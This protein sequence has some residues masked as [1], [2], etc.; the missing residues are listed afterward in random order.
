MHVKILRPVGIPTSDTMS[1]TYRD[2][3]HANPFD[4]NRDSRYFY[5]SPAHEEALGRLKYLAEDGNFGLGMLSGT[6]GSGKSLIRTIFHA[7]LD[8]SRFSSV[9]IENSLLDLDG[10]LLEILSQM[11]GKRYHPEDVPDRYSKISEFKRLLHDDIVKHSRHLIISIDEAQML[12]NATLEGV[13][14]LTNINSSQQ[15]LMTV[16]LIGQPELQSVVKGLPQ[17]DQRIGL[18]CRIGNLDREETVAY[19]NHRIEIAQLQQKTSI[20][21]YMFHKL[22]RAT[23][24]N[25]RLINGL[26]KLALEHAR[27]NEKILDDSSLSAVISDQCMPWYETTDNKGLTS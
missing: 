22:Y 8:K 26:F 10:L 3:E 1:I 25:P 18:R 9:V 16:L 5:P 24:G 27:L 6:T 2:F 23:Q 21:E 19:I 11:R 15:N 20:S 7:H 12:S 13:R 4:S 17:L 14:S